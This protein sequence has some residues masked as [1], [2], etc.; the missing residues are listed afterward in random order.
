MHLIITSANI[1]EHFEHRRSQYI[2]SINTA[3]KYA[4]SCLSITVLECF[5]SKVP[6]LEDFNVVYSP[7]ANVFPEKGLNEL[8]HLKSF[9]LRSPISNDE[10][11][12]KLTGRYL[13]EDSTFF[14]KVLILK[15]QYNCIIKND[16]D[17]YEGRGCHTFLF[18]AKKGLLLDAI[19]SFDFSS[20][21]VDP[22]EWG[23]KAFLEKR[24]D[25]YYMERL[26]VRAF[27]G[28]SGANIFSS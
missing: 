9:L 22:I 25:V 10:F 14:H 19:E 20:S 7:V 4:Y 17:I 12:V 27:Q 2:E 18:A 8:Q 23:I 21:S 3:V 28:T 6:Y 11:I 13:L 24:Q 16:K 1:D 26:G 5:A 15:D